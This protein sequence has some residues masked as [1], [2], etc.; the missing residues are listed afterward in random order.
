MPSSPHDYESVSDRDIQ[1]NQMEGGKDAAINNMEDKDEE[2]NDEEEVELNIITPPSQVCEA[3]INS[4]GE[5]QS[6]LST[7]GNY[8]SLMDVH[9]TLDQPTIY[10]QLGS[11]PAVL[12]VGTDKGEGDSMEQ[13]EPHT[14]YNIH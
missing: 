10:S 13:S 5:V 6:D 14:Y 8:S 7:S 2:N 9:T 11:L 4:T 12:P 3:G 1:M